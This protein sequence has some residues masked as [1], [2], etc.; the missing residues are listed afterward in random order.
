MVITSW[1]RYQFL[2]G[3]HISSWLAQDN[4]V[5]KPIRG[6]QP[7]G[8]RQ[9]LAAQGLLTCDDLEGEPLTTATGGV[10]GGGGS[11]VDLLG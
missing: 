6:L 5:H 11:T 9:L 2:V 1:L 4:L 10:V 8:V 7:P 3:C